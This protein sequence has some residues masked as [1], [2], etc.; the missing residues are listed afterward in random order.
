RWMQ[1]AVGAV[2]GMAR[3]HGMDASGGALWA[4]FATACVFDCVDVFVARLE[5][6]PCAPYE[7]IGGLIE[8]TS[9]YYFYGGSVRIQE[10]ALLN[11]LEKLLLGSVLLALPNGWRWRLI[12]TAAANLL[13]LHHFVFSMRSP[14]AP[15]AMYPFV[16]V[17]S[18]SLL[19]VSLAIV[20][21]TAA[22]HSLARI[23]D[24]L[25]FARHTPQPHRAVALYD[26][27]GV[28]QGTAA[29]DDEDDALLDLAP[30]V[31]M[32][33][34]PDLRRD[35]SVEILDL[36]GTCLQ[37]CSNQIRA[38][39]LA[40][41]CG[42]IRLPR[43]TALDEYV[44]RVV[45]AADA[46]SACWREPPARR[47][48]SGLSAFVEDEPS[49]VGQVPTNTADLIHVLRDTRANSVR[50]L[51]LGMWALIAALGHYALERKMGPLDPAFGASRRGA[52]KLGRLA[53][54]SPESAAGSPSDD[55]DESDYDFI[56][57][58][59]DTSDASDAELE[60]DGLVGETAALVGDILSGTPDEQPSDRLAAAVAFMAHSLIDS[61]SGSGPAVMTR[62]MYARQVARIGEPGAPLLGAL[63]GLY[64]HAAVSAAVPAPFARGETESLA[65][66]IQGRR[67]AVPR[68]DDSRSLCV[69]CWTNP[70]CVML[71]P[72]RCLCLCN[73]CRAALVVRN[74]DHCPCCRRG[75]A[76][77]SRVYAV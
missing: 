52:E 25:G 7:Y 42:A 6:S 37:Q 19:G 22:V 10:L 60:P 75:V 13:M 69:V 9:L 21:V 15:H 70:R 14:S 3:R 71:R 50:R 47:G 35:F 67:S 59:S 12:P 11:A 46:G 32:P 33:I 54:P 68:D 5:G 26:R 53:A 64:Q 74:F 30:D 40:R 28:F 2:A 20:L 58:I 57:A 1:G 77:Y 43:T 48:R 66:L 16:Q 55:E 24:R 8:R 41:P 17:L 18:M 61:S 56:C 39:G 62:S 63:S 49:V 29:D 31:S 34:V 76:G 44:D 27:H 4:S 36:A 45:G 23:V 51:S 65:Q 38:T 73:D 72:C